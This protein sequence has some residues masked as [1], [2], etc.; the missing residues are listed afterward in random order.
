M[1]RI[2]R[3]NLYGNNGIIDRIGWTYTKSFSKPR[4]RNIRI[5][6][7]GEVLLPR[8]F[9]SACFRRAASGDDA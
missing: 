3:M 6:D 1:E 5:T 7:I 2:V 4:R 9:V 8:R